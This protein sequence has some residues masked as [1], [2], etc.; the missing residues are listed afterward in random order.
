MGR[1]RF[2][3][4]ESLRVDISEGDWVEIKVRLTAGEQKRLQS[5][6]ITHLAKDDAHPDEGQF[7]LNIPAMAV[8]RILTWLVDWSFKDKNGRTAPLTRESV[9]A[10]DVDTFEELEAV[11]TAHIKRQDEEK[12]LTTIKMNSAASSA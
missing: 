9:E 7:T 6:A 3:E 8:A 10:L 12:K 5:S 11:V 1:N 2:V 4:P